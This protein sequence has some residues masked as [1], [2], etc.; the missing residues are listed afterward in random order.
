MRLSNQVKKRGSRDRCICQAP[1]FTTLYSLGDFIRASPAV[2][3]DSIATCLFD[4]QGN[5]QLLKIFLSV[6][7]SDSVA[8]H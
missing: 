1:T 3:S 5:L 8:A 7:S 4:S 2:H 6:M